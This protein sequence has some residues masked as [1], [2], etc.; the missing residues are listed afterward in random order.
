MDSFTDAMDFSDFE[1]DTDEI[2]CPL[3]ESSAVEVT[4]GAYQ[5]LRCGESWKYLVLR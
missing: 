1:V 5:C 2:Q 3:C 4:D